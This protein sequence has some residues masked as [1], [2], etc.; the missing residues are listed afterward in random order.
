LNR[1][2]VKG[3]PMLFDSLPAVPLSDRP[4][5][6]DVSRQLT[7]QALRSSASLIGE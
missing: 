2:P 1:L 6:P 5:I 4:V 3:S 7:F